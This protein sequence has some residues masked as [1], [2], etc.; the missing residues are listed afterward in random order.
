MPLRLRHTYA[1]GIRCGLPTG[2]INRPKS[3]LH[4]GGGARRS[5]AQIRQVRAGGLPLRGV[6]ALVHCRYTF[7]S[8]LPDPHHLTVLARPG[9]VRA[10]CHPPRRLPSQAALSFTRPAATSRQWCPFITTRFKS[11]SWR[12]MSQLHTW[13][14]AVAINSGFFFAGWVR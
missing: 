13:F 10:A 5:P 7:P 4:R 2:D 1:A 3:S 14:A 6:H 11:A 8:C 12:S 9:F